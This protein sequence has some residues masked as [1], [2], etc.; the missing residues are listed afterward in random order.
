MA[1]EFG[2]L[3]PGFND[4]VGWGA[5]WLGIVSQRWSG[6]TI[7]FDLGAAY[8][9]LHRG[10]LFVGTSWKVRMIGKSDPSPSSS[11]SGNSM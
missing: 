8:T 1:T 10:D 2:A 5:S 9:R 3:M 11:M 4:E 7:H 6:G